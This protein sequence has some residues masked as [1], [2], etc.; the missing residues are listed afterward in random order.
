[1]YYTDAGLTE[2]YTSGSLA[3]QVKES[4]DGYRLPTDTEW[5]YAARGG[6]VGRR[7]SWSDS[8]EIQ[9][10]RANYKSTEGDVYDTSPTRGY[11]PTYYTG[12]I[13]YSAPVGSFAAN[14]YGLRDMTGNVSEWCYDWAPQFI[15]HSR[16]IRGGNWYEAAYYARIGRSS[17]APPD[18]GYHQLGFR[19]VLHPGP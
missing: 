19:T 8:D 17:M 11:H 7:F 15:G 2:I 10:V 14:G 16:V 6:A 4:A 18:S 12:G 3:P 9:H 5:R 13:P 1:M